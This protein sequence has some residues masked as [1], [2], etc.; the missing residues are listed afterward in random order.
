[1]LNSMPMVNISK[2]TPSSESACVSVQALLGA[3][4][5]A[6]HVRPEDDA[7]EQVAEHRRLL[8]PLRQQARHRRR[9]EDDAEVLNGLREIAGHRGSP[10]Y[11]TGRGR[12]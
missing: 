1:M 10:G 3:D 9:R 5:D 8:D 4:D 11:T 7:R 6:R 2:M 12:A